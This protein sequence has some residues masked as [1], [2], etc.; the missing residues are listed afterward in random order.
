MDNA[1]TQLG[2]S[3]EPVGN[4][5][6]GEGASVI[7]AIYKKNADTLNHRNKISTESGANSVTLVNIY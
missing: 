7:N 2:C 5:F 4:I 6:G 3:L 1:T